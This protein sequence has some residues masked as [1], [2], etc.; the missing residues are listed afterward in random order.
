[1]AGA[2]RT[3]S[4]IINCPLLGLSPEPKKGGKIIQHPLKIEISNYAAATQ[5]PG[6]AATD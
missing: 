3:E 2:D 4:H 1:M 6:N 5:K